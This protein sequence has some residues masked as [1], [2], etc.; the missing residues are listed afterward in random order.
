MFVFS[1]LAFSAVASAQPTCLTGADQEPCDGVVILDELQNYIQLWYGCS[2]CYPD[3]YDAIVAW[4]STL[5]TMPSCGDGLCNGNE[6]CSNCEVDCGQCGGPIQTTSQIEQFGI[7]WTFDKEYQYGQFANGDYWVVPDEPGENVTIIGIDPT[8]VVKMGITTQQGFVETNAPI[9]GTDPWERTMHGSM[10]NPV[11]G[12]LYQGYDS[13]MYAWHSSGRIWDPWYRDNLNVG[14]DMPLDII[15]N[16]SLISSISYEQGQLYQLKTAAILTVLGSAPAA[17]SFRPAYCG[18]DKKISFNSNTVL[19]N[20]DLLQ[21]L[22]LSGI[23]SYAVD[24]A[25]S[26]TEALHKDV[27]TDPTDQDETV[28]RMFER[29]WLDHASWGDVLPQGINWPGGASHPHYN[30]QAYG[31]DISN[32][33]GVAAL[34]LNS[35][36]IDQQKKTL[37]IRMV[38]TGIDLYGVAMNGG[39][40]GWKPDGGHRSGRKF[41]ILLAGMMLDDNNPLTTADNAMRDIGAIDNPS[42]PDYIYFHEDDQT[43]YVDQ[44]TIDINVNDTPIT[45]SQDDIGLPE[46]GIRH[47]TVPREDRK[48]WKYYGDNGYRITD[49]ARAWNGFVLAAHA[50]GVK[51]LWNHEALFDYEDRFMEVQASEVGIGSTW[52]SF[53]KFSEDVWDTYRTRYGCVWTRD[54]QSDIHSQG[55]YNCTDCLEN[56]LSGSYC[57]DGAC[58]GAE[59][60]QSCAYDCEGG[61]EEPPLPTP[62]G[63]VYYVSPA[64]DGSHN[65]LDWDNAFNLD[66]A[67]TNASGMPS[68]EVTYLLASGDYNAVT[69]SGGNDRTAWATFKAYEPGVVFS[70]SAGDAL[71]IRGDVHRYFEFNGINVMVDGPQPAEN[72]NY[73]AIEITDSDYLSFRNCN[74]T[75]Y[76]EEAIDYN[77]YARVTD[78]LFYVNNGDA[79]ELAGLI[80]EN[81]TFSQAKR[82]I[83]INDDLASADYPLIFANN[84]VHTVCRSGI[85]IERQAH[86][87]GNHGTILIEGNTMYNQQSKDQDPGGDTD[88]SHG[89]GVAISTGNMLIRNNHIH[90][91]GATG[92][93]ASYESDAPTGG[94][95]D[96]IIEK[97]LIYDVRGWYPVRLY[98]LGT[99]ILVNNNTIIGDYDSASGMVRYSYALLFQIDASADGTGISFN[100][101]MIVG[102]VLRQAAM[103]EYDEDYN[104]IYSATSSPGFNHETFLKGANTIIYYQGS[105]TPQNFESGFFV[106]PDYSRGND[107]ERSPGDGGPNRRMDLDYSPLSTSDA[108]NGTVVPQPGYVGALPCA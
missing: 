59:T 36:F 16:S 102:T 93:I 8:S 107:F 5:P 82:G 95:T 21:K 78:A 45:Y 22:D 91:M 18:D 31:R 69:I 47:T 29:P 83:V 10:L 71:T 58:N 106:N 62:E 32:Q 46:W 57:G 50:M 15:P 64:G 74:V 84:T 20:M 92:G 35:N 41:P 72:S 90:S 75:G 54:N 89:S 17:G 14:L 94:F 39:E 98:G 96:L 44:N 80:M 23:T 30:M 26:H 33:V 27:L 3:L 65:G 85:S 101:N 9:N 86:A 66:E 38:Q 40:E 11:S 1:F 108:C 77:A 73:R 63:N 103:T 60:N 13:E 7:T 2:S 48:E 12:T 49:N 81:C 56:C 6:V 28:E 88:Y 67:I 55:H 24:G 61:D 34:M 76:W 25:S 37:T 87:Q 100:N 42:D 70:N 68:I 104:I 105:G 99:N 51:W 79:N 43:F 53:S 97:N 4:Y 52:R 19:G